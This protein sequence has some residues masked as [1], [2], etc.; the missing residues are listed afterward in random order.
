MVDWRCLKHMTLS[1]VPSEPSGGVWGYQG[2]EGELHAAATLS[3]AVGRAGAR[4]TAVGLRD[5]VFPPQ[6]KILTVLGR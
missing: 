3:Q 2:G 6:R 4:V 1:L 5:H